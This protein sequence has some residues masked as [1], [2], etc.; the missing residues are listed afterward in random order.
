MLNFK[1]LDCTIRDGGYYTNW[2]FD[3][4]LV[5]IYLSSFNK[6]PIDY[7]EIGYRSKKL[8]GYFGEFFYC[9]LY[10]L[11][12]I[13]IK[14]N[15]KIA[16]ILNEKDVK[17]DDVEEL[18][19]SCGD[20]IDMVR[21]AIAP[22]NFERAITLGK[23]IKSFGF[24]LCFNVMYMSEWEGNKKFIN[25]VPEIDGIVDY[26]YMVDSYG[27]V[28]PDEIKKTI[29]Q[30]RNLTSCK[31]G[32]H[33][34]N[35]LE[36]A[37][38]NTITAIEEG[39]DI[40]D[41]TV[42]GMGRGAGNLKME[43]FLTYLNS[44]Y[45]LHLEYNELSLVTDGF[46]RLQNEHEWGTNLPYMVAGANSI[47]QKQVMDW[48]SKRFY[49]FN[50]IIRALSNQTEGVEDNIDLPEFNWKNED[51]KYLIIG[52]GNSVSRHK[53]ALLNFL[54]DNSQTVLIHASSKNVQ[55]FKDLSNKQIHVLSGNEGRRLEVVFDELNKENRIA[56][57]PPYPRKMGTYIPE[58]IIEQS[59]QIKK[60]DVFEE[61]SESVT[62]ICLEIAVRGGSQKIYFA[63]YDGYEGEISRQELEL[64]NENESIFKVI[65]D[66]YKLVSLTP[67]KYKNLLEDSIYSEVK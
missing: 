63:G 51:A 29:K 32:F 64:F 21:I 16:I 23:K 17:P 49:S 61:F 13:K 24:E 19:G 10:K 50:S 40:V 30:L 33:G 34:H 27:G 31:L 66:N 41:A 25:R 67:T 56:V 53:E 18:L 37:L 55:E 7:I 6:L 20:Y 1:I 28:F 62:S 45:S 22:D 47:P 36:M 9:P 38:A 35:N 60:N 8:E 57:L 43:L 11:R 14:T 5:D 39:V 58:K 65:R 59:F 12:D 48:V 46:M 42:T 52:G 3:N 2:D 4:E 54:H 44:K 26:L 15:K